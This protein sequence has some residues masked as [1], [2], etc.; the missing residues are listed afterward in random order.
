MKIKKFLKKGHLIPTTTMEVSFNRNVM[1]SKQ[2]KQFI[3]KALVAQF[4][5]RLFAHEKICVLRNI[6]HSRDDVLPHFTFRIWNDL[7][8]TRDIPFLRMKDY[9]GYV[10]TEEDGS[11][12]LEFITQYTNQ[13]EI[14]VF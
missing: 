10:W 7:V 1:F 14:A 4:Q 6:H 3:H 12:S 13:K 2:E 5:G 9:H 8:S 11:S